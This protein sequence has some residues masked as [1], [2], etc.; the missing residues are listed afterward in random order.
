MSNS[1]RFKQNLLLNTCQQHVWLEIP[2]LS[3]SKLAQYKRIMYPRANKS[4]GEQLLKTGAKRPSPRK[5]T[6]QTRTGKAALIA[7][8]PSHRKHT[9]K[10]TVVSGAIGHSGRHNKQPPWSILPC[11]KYGDLSHKCIPDNMVALLRQCQEVQESQMEQINC[12]ALAFFGLTWVSALQCLF[13]PKHEAIVP[14]NHVWDHLYTRH[15]GRFP[16]IGR[17]KVLVGFLG[18]V[19]VCHPSIVDQSAQDIISTLPHKLPEDLPSIPIAQRYQC[20]A[21]LECK[22]WISTTKS[23]GAV[24]SEY[25]KHLKKDHVLNV[26]DYILALKSQPQWTQKVMIHQGMNS[27]Y[28]YFIASQVGDSGR[29]GQR[30]PQ[31]LAAPPSERWPI[32]LGWE[33]EL[34]RISGILLQSRED[35]IAYLQDLVAL[36]SRDRV[37]R[38]TDN[39]L[40]AIELGL[41][42]SNAANISYFKDVINWIS[43]K[44]SSFRFLFSH[45]RY[46]LS[47]HLQQLKDPK[48]CLE[49]TPFFCQPMNM[50]YIAF[51][52]FI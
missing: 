51:G 52:A 8:S 10:S 14:G 11:C 45:D 41:W 37:F 18:H 3:P 4:I 24:D 12:P 34:Q 26:D 6:S 31:P 43:T 5:I 9:Q 35:T 48:L 15:S 13:C 46:V 7:K 22:Q 27:P 49:S 16:G 33:A 17:D 2:R 30:V 42:K 21:N 39:I 32:E 19:K 28:V 47:F 36:P 38:C 20:S 50:S 1:P 25:R 40:K 44:H 29:E 23:K